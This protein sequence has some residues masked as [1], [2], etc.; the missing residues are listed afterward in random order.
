MKALIILVAVMLPLA[1][2]ASAE[3]KAPATA[4]F[5]SLD[6][7]GDQSIDKAEARA[8]RAVAAAFN[9]AD[10]NLD[11]YI[12]KSEYDVWLQRSSGAPPKQE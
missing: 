5:K 8:D 10:I 11:G 2:A 7:N 12:S 4:T 3:P 6:R 1:T 9:T